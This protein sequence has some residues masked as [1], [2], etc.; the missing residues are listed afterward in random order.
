MANENDLMTQII[1]TEILIKI[2]TFQ[3]NKSI[4]LFHMKNKLWFIGE[5][6]L[7]LIIDYLNYFAESRL[8][9]LRKECLYLC[10]S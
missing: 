8:K 9:K 10:M 1:A 7:H 2:Y 6:L 5:Q 3:E 4:S